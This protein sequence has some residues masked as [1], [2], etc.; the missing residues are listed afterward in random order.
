MK[1]EKKDYL[2]GL[3]DDAAGSGLNG[4]NNEPEGT[5]SDAFLDAI[6]SVNGKK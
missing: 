2:D 6:K 1:Q 3:K 4:V 5:T